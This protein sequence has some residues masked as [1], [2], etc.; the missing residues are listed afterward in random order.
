MRKGM[1][2]V[3]REGDRNWKET[4]LL[5]FYLLHFS[6]ARGGYQ[7]VSPRRNHREPMTVDLL[8]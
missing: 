3:T 5:T 4:G 6:G 8:M 2:E 7:G 1:F